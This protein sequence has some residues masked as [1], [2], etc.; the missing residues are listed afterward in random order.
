MK[1][2]SKIFL[3]CALVIV[4]VGVADELKGD[5]EKIAPVT[6]ISESGEKA[7]DA[8]EKKSAGG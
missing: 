7:A 1:L 8:K 3:T 6:V 5:L 2:A 4:V